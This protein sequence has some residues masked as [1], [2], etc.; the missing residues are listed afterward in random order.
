MI[1]LD[2]FKENDVKEYPE[3][4]TA[5]EKYARLK[6]HFD[7]IKTELDFLKQEIMDQYELNPNSLVGVS[8]SPVKGRTTIK[9]AEIAE[10]MN[11]PQAVISAHTKTGTQSYQV[12]VVKP[13]EQPQ[14]YI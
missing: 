9:W 5:G 3:E 13:E 11:I 1:L 10:E 14:K 12:R 6:G 2:H 8:V 4:Q 7:E